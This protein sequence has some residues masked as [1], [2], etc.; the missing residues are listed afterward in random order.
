MTPDAAPL[1]HH[2]AEINSITM[3][4]VEQGTGLPIV[5]CHGFPHS[6]YSWHRQI[7]ALVEAGCHVIA[8]DMRGMGLSAA[9]EDPQAYN[10]ETICA[11]LIGLLD[12]LG[13]TQAVFAGL[14]FG[15]FAAHDLAMRYPEK[16]K[17]L[18]MLENP[19]PPHNP[20]ISP[21]TEYKEMGKDH[22][23]HINYFCDTPG[24]ADADM[25]ARVDAFFPKVFWALSAGGN[26]FD[27]FNHPIGTHYI[28]ALNLAPPLDWDWL[29]AEEMQ[30]FIDTYKQSG[31]TGGL[32]WYRSMDIKWQ[33]RQATY[34][35]TSPVPAYF[36]GSEEDVD[37]KGFHGDDP[38]RLLKRQF[39]D[40]RRVDM[41]STA[42]HLVQLEKSDEVNAVL[43]SFIADIK[44]L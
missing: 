26:Y 39:P 32:N 23:L 30:V 14:D 1:R 12:H 42:G 6:W 31:F 2:Q 24:V 27:T 17:A 8:P 11:D 20:D 13:L 40:L 10:V 35:Q 3:H 21:L 36:L 38:I 28:D 16:V 25:L 5:L 29:S 7:P 44:T 33:E 22:F 9:P 34:H 18:I 15:A 37:L 43:K 19:A 4:Y 41:V